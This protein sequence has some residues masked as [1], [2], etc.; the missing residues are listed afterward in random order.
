ML[1]N[2]REVS[3]AY[4][5]HGTPTAVLVQVDGTIGS[6]VAAGAVQIEQLLRTILQQPADPPVAQISNPG[7]PP[8]NGASLKA[9]AR[10]PAAAPL[11]AMAAGGRPVP[12]ITLPDLAGDLIDLH[13]L[14]GRPTVLLFWNPNCGFC[15][16]MVDDLKIWGSERPDGSPDLLILSSGDIDA[17]QVMELRLP[18]LIDDGFAAGRQF[19]ATGT[20]SA[21]LLNG[22][23][24][25]A[26][27]VMVGA[28]NVMGLLDPAR[29]VVPTN[30]NGAQQPL[31]PLVRMGS[32][33]PGF[34][35]SDL[36]GNVITQAW[37]RGTETLV[38][39][40]D[41]AC[42]FCQQMLDDLRAL[43]TDD[44]VP[45]LLVVSTGAV[46]VNRGLGLRSTIALDQGFTVGRRFGASGTPSAVLVDRKGKIAST[47]AAGAPAVL[48][49]ARS[50]SGSTTA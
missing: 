22:D 33:A 43:E 49:L 3:D 38:L 18:F 1:Q 32:P 25:I 23:G 13:D 21:V 47:L 46:E 42:G 7:A 8:S 37:L 17:R 20:P 48:G 12:R 11:N 14:G 28:D 35:L 10:L 36:N 27:N 2:E 40:W 44:S 34:E 24:K 4:Q 41:P 15:R 16:Q 29:R 45:R 5:A 30:G 19:G 50:S 39:F 6:P 9:T 31:A 26:S